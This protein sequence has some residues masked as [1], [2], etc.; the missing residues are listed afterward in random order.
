MYYVG[1]STNKIDFI[2]FLKLIKIEL[3][4]VRPVLVYDNH[5][6]HTS[7]LA[8]EF[9]NEQFTPLR[10]P[11]YSCEFNSIEKVWSQLKATFKTEMA[12]RTYEIANR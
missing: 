11:K 3:G 2:E 12:Q 7:I 1:K 6:S 4:D 5:P 10:L 8:R 9:I